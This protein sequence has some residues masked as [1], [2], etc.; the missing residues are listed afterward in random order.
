MA[1]RVLKHYRA[2][3]PAVGN[4]IFDVMG[5]AVPATRA[6]VARVIVAV[7]QVSQIVTV[8]AG[9][10]SGNDTILTYNTALDAGETWEQSGIVLLA[11]ERVYVRTDN[12]VAGNCIASV[13]GEE[14]D[15]V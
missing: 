12:A 13:H 5:A 4:Q 7:A 6:L 10:G 2:T 1:A 11:G 15:N 14:V 8:Y 3:N 9:N